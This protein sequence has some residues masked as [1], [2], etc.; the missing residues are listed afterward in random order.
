MVNRRELEGL[1]EL[2]VG[3]LHKAER[4][5]Q[6]RY[7]GLAAA[8]GEKRREFLQS[9]N[10]LQHRASLAEHLIATMESASASLEPLAA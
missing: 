5:L 9:L 1:I 2:V 8:D 4:E 6:Q 10:D 7:G 3:D